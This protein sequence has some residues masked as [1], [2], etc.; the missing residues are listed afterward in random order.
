ML[1]NYFGRSSPFVYWTQDLPFLFFPTYY[2]GVCV[3]FSNIFDSIVV[4]H[5][6]LKTLCHAAL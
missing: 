6:L 5:Y 3:G 4:Q 2:Y 1:G